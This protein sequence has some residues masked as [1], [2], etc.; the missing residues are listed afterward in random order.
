MYHW[1]KK[2]G[3]E[4]LSPFLGSVLIVR[5]GL[6]ITGDLKHPSSGFARLVR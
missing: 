3:E 1:T 4:C 6:T 2:K 5:L